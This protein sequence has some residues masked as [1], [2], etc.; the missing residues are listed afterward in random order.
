[1]YHLVRKKKENFFPKL[2][3]LKLHNFK[4]QI[5]YLDKKYHIVNIDDLKDFFVKKK[6]FKKNLCMLT[7]DDGYLSHYN[8]VF[9]ILKQKGLQGFFFPPS[10]AIE[11]CELTDQNKVQILLAS[12][13]A[14]NYLNEE[15]KYTTTSSF[16]SLNMTV[17]Q[18]WDYSHTDPT[19]VE[20]G[21]V[22]NLYTAGDLAATMGVN[23]DLK[24]FQAGGYFDSVTPFNQ[25]NLDLNNMQIENSL[26]KNIVIK[27]YPSGHMVYLEGDSRKLMKKDLEKFYDIA[28]HDPLAMKRILKLQEK[29]L[30]INGKK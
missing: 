27:N 24:V 25:T 12:G 17:G 5:N 13:V 18:Y 16:I 22:S 7:F 28:T 14:A 8:Y 20:K 1:M 23:P 11:N 21:G 4:K 6:K 3:S 15:L 9:P 19:G 10:K 30:S 29:T 2:V 26:R